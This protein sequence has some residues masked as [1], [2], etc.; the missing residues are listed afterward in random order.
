MK[1]HQGGVFGEED[2]STGLTLTVGLTVTVGVTTTFR[3]T[4]G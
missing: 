4:L 1:L 2:A 3:V